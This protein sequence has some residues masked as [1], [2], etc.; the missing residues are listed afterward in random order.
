MKEREFLIYSF[1]LGV[2]ITFLYDFFRILRRVIAHKGFWISM[3]D[4][5]F[6]TYTCMSVFL[7]MHRQGEGN[8]RWFAV[9]GALAG[10]LLYKKT[11]SPIY[12]RFGTWLF[13]WLLWPIKK[14][15]R[16]LTGLMRLAGTHMRA[17]VH[18]AGC[19]VQRKRKSA[20]F[21]L[22]KKLTFFVRLLKMTIG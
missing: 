12:I 21:H 18:K 20:F 4:F 5:A 3:E 13:T 17:A 11:V 16:C 15:V 7:L 1:L 14:V 2:F 22:K 10:M 8:L 19:G 6:W 9:M